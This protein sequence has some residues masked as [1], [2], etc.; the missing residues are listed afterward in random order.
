MCSTCLCFSDKS[1]SHLKAV[2]PCVSWPTTA[3]LEEV[4]IWTGD[5]RVVICHLEGGS[6]HCS[7]PGH[8]T[9]KEPDVNLFPLLNI[10]VCFF[11]LLVAVSLRYNSH[12]IQITHLKCIIQ[13]F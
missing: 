5:W 3:L 7:G 8:R 13:W 6:V 12:T 9:C 11:F 10:L 2:F 4:W 1:V